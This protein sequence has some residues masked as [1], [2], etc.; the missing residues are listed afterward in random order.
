MVN[1]TKKQ[2]QQEQQTNYCNSETV[3]PLLKKINEKNDGVCIHVCCMVVNITGV[4]LTHLAGG[5][6][7]QT[8][9][10]VRC[11]VEVGWTGTLVASARRQ[12]TQVATAAIVHLAWVVLH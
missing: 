12:Q 11:Q 10:S 8:L 3:T 5:A 7:R 6:V 2:Q 4:M 1:K 9:A